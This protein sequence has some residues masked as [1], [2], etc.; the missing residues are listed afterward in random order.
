MARAK[1]TM[2]STLD[3]TEAELRALRLRFQPGA[4]LTAEDCEVI[5]ALVVTLERITEQL[6]QKNASLARLRVLLFGPRSERTKDVLPGTGTDASPAGGTA[7]PSGEAGAG[8]ADAPKPDASPKKKRPGHGR[9]G[10]DAYTSATRIRVPHTQLIVG[11][12]CPDCGHGKLHRLP[13][14]TK[15]V[16]V[17]G[18]PCLHA[19]IWEGEQFRCGACGEVFPAD[20]P[21]EARGPKYDETAGSMI[22]VLKYGTGLPNH[23]LDKL[24]KDL[25]IPVPAT[26]Q[27]EIASEVSET[28][29]PAFEELL[30]QAAQAD[31]LHHDDTRAKILQK[32]GPDQRTGTF[33][34]SIVA[35][36]DGHDI[37]LFF[38]GRRHAGE[39]LVKL[40]ER[41]LPG[42]EPPIQMCD[43]LSRN[44]P[45]EL[46][47]IL[48][49]CVAHG[50]RKFV[51]VAK[52]FPA[53]CRRVLDD[54]AVVYR[55]DAKTREL[56]LS[57]PD[58]LAYHREHSAKTMT[59]LHEWLK[60]Q[61]D[62]KRVEPNSTLG[63]AISYMLEHWPEM[64]Q[65][66]K[67]PGAPLDNNICERALKMAILLRKN[68]L[69]YKTEAGAA[70]GDLLMSL[71]YTCRMNG[72]NPFV[73]LNELQRNAV[74]LREQP[75]A[76][77]PWNFTETLANLKTRAAAAAG[78]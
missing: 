50:R 77:M 33:T 48:T 51:A 13:D 75:A 65:F 38:T 29:A 20:L 74:S 3:L 42:K 56:G 36:K 11:Q 61:F 63:R 57:P 60:A 69:F 44:Y 46:N 59:D 39:N 2:D 58:R 49:K 15:T 53:E 66:L 32:P 22:A 73:Y 9:N 40:L 12:T 19:T 25:G 71:I 55:N 41:R 64:T 7:P 68:A 35:R 31:V 5:Q 17:V 62:E 43:A 45:E 34:T 18:Q 10:A 37:A 70:V 6:G 4:V 54:L 47:T 1:P 8:G 76:W 21:A 23:R 78:V 26:V 28:V 30:N 16:R 27:S 72:A 52:C 14:F 67:V 24:Q